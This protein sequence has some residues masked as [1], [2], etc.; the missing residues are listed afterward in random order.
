MDELRNRLFSLPDWGYVIYRTTYTAESDAAFSHAIR[1]IEACLKNEFFKEV[2]Q[3]PRASLE[4]VR[5]HFE[6]WVDSQGMRDKF[7]KYR[8]CLII[9]DE[10]LQTLKD[11][12][13]ENAENDTVELRFVK[14]LEAFPIMD[15]LETFP[16]W[17]KCWT[18]TLWF[19]WQNM[20]DGDE[21]RQLYDMIDDYP[22]FE[23]VFCG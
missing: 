12:P 13:V 21:M 15:S 17:M 20:G 19:L 2:T 18:Q 14:A 3:Q 23:G 9:D 11:T 6:A 1:Y 22:G 8:V 16:G 7:N 10:S 5:A 4:T